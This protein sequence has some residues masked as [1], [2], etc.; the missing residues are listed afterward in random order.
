[1][2]TLTDQYRQWTALEVDSDSLP[3]PEPPAEHCLLVHVLRQ[4]LM[5]TRAPQAQVRTEAR[6]WL[7]SADCDALCAALGLEADTVRRVA[8]T[9]PMA[10]LC[11]GR[12]GPKPGHRGRRVEG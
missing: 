9:I 1:M 8:P 12:R 6:A 10:T 3:D 4:A 11:A 2:V 5:D 7:E